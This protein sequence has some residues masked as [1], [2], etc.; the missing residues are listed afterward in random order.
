MKQSIFFKCLYGFVKGIYYGFYHVKAEGK[1]NLPKEPGFIIASNHRTFADPPLIA[2]TSMCAKFSFIAKEELFHNKFFGWLIRKLGA[3][4]VVRGSGD[5]KVISDSVER[6][7]EGRNLVIFPE[8]TR[9]KDGKLG[10]GKTGVALIAAK[11]GAMVVPA[12]V[13]FEGKKL[14]FRKKVIVRYGKPIPPTD[15]E[16]GD[17]FDTRQL[18]GVKQKIMGDIQALLE[19]KNG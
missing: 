12:A 15:I 19:D 3:F 5:M 9:S 13:V 8:G 10:R 18:K 6:L 17:N 1:E 7:R 14:H 11:S 2:A 4:P 16:I